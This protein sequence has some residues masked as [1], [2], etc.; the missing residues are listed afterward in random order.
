MR[1]LGVKLASNSDI[2]SASEIVET[3]RSRVMVY[4]T[5]SGDALQNEIGDL[6]RLL[7]MYRKGIIRARK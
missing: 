6:C 3:E 2:H 4:H 5:D 7:E 1:E